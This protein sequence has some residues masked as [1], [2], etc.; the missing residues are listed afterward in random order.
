MYAK[1]INRNLCLRRGDGQIQEKD[2]ERAYSGSPTNDNWYH[3]RRVYVSP[4]GIKIVV[5]DTGSTGRKYHMILEGVLISSSTLV[6]DELPKLEIFDNLNNLIDIGERVAITKWYYDNSLPIPSFGVVVSNNRNT[7][8]VEL[9]NKHKGATRWG[10][11]LDEV[12]KELDYDPNLKMISINLKEAL[13]ALH[14]D[15][16]LEH[17]ILD[18]EDLLTN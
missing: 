4:D 5:I 9:D 2:H 15:K 18:M 10:F 16:P 7:Y 8:S 6:E 14:A 13:D 1:V 11:N 3:V 12:V 17:I